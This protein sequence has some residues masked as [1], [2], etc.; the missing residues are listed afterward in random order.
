M[1][2]DSWGCKEWDT[3]ERLKGTD[4]AIS[5]KVLLRVVSKKAQVRSDK[6]K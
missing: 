3:T 6:C 1:C 2:C 4:E 5:N